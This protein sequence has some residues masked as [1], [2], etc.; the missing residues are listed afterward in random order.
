MDFTK[1][2]LAHPDVKVIGV[3][4][5]HQIIGRAL[6]AKVMKHDEGAWETSVCEVEQTSKG[7]EL[8]GG[9]DR[10]VSQSHDPNCLHEV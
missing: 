8:F 5:G 2:A 7:K 9:K 10:L 4:Y 6:G 3:C 1:Q